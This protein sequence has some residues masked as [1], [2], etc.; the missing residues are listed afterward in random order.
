MAPP[1][2]QVDGAGAL[3]DVDVG[4]EH[5][6]ELVE[7]GA[8]RLHHVEQLRQ[9]LDGLEQV[10]ERSTKNVTVPTVRVASWTQP[11]TDP[12]AIAVASDTGSSMTGGTRWTPSPTHVGVVESYGCGSTANRRLLGSSRAKAWMTRTPAMPSWSCDRCRRCRRARRGRRRWSRAGT[13]G[14]RGPRDSAARCRAVPGVDPTPPPD[15]RRAARPGRRGRWWPGGGRSR[16][17]CARPSPR[18]WRRGSR[19]PWTGRPPTWR[20]RG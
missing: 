13:C 9:L 3:G 8:G 2:G 15:R 19:A 20:R 12:T 18:P 10:R 14:R 7:R 17:W 5:P 4:V 16:W 6:E 1:G 11:A